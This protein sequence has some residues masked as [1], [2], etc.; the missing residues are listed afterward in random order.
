MLRPRAGG[1]ALV[2]AVLHLL[3]ATACCQDYIVMGTPKVNIR[4]GPAGPVKTPRV[5]SST[6]SWCSSAAPDSAPTT[7]ARANAPRP[8]ACRQ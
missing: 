5:S 7:S 1:M 8:G 2:L 6:G 4:T 3:A